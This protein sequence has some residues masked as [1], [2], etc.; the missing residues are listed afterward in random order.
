MEIADHV[1]DFAA[2][3]PRGAYLKRAKLL[4]PAD[5]D[6]WYRCGLYELVDGKPDRAWASWRWSLTLSD[7][8]LREILERSRATLG[9]LDILRSVLPDQPDLLVAAAVSLYPRPDE[10]RRPFQERARVLLERRPNPLAGGDLHLLA[11]IY[12]GLG[13]PADALATYRAALVREPLRLDWRQERA[14]LSFEQC[15]FEESRQELYAIL[16]LRPDDAQARAL[17]DAVTRKIAAGL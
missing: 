9:P 14:A 5:P 15:R 8:Y 13:R 16:S 2:A 1:E 12:A 7:L 3:E 10:G 11:T 17:L 4:A 6:L